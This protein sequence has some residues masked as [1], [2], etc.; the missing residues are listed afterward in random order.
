MNDVAMIKF[1]FTSICLF[2]CLG[3]VILTNGCATYHV[4]ENNLK[5][6]DYTTEI[7]QYDSQSFYIR[8]GVYSGTVFEDNAEWREYLFEG[9]LSGGNRVFRILV[10]TGVS[11]GMGASDLLS[12][13]EWNGPQVKISETIRQNDVSTA[14]RVVF[15]PHGPNT[16]EGIIWRLNYELPTLDITK[17]GAHLLMIDDV[18][19]GNDVL[20]FRHSEVPDNGLSQWIALSTTRDIQWKK[21]SKIL[22]SFRKLPYILT[23]P[24]DLLTSPIQL[25]LFG[26]ML[27][28]C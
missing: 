19:S 23:V 18:F 3:T 25:L 14:A 22:A 16:V 24:F 12:P 15:I 1:I 17:Y 5:Y 13:S 6:Q 10:P 2:L 9:I 26:M 11:Q 21:R 4:W 7:T 8:D 28:S 20:Y 27:H